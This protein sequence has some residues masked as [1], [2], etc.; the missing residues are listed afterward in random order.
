MENSDLVRV[1]MI[2]AFRGYDH[3]YPL[4][5]ILYIAFESNPSVLLVPALKYTQCLMRKN[6]PFGKTHDVWGLM[7]AR[8]CERKI[9]TE[10]LTK[11]M[12][13]IKRRE[14]ILE[15]AKWCFHWKGCDRTMLRYRFASCAFSTPT[16]ARLP[17]IKIFRHICKVSCLVPG[18]VRTMPCVGRV[19]FVT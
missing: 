5:S 15:M 13:V 12:I 17:H 6:V 18:N 1:F 19:R 14:S 2:Y 3:L 11:Q 8:V 7:L 16:P 4:R 9:R 10:R